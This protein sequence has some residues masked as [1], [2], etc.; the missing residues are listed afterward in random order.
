MQQV[1]L[2]LSIGLYHTTQ[3][4]LTCCH[5]LATTIQALTVK[6]YSHHSCCVCCRG[7]FCV[8]ATH[9]LIIIPDCTHHAGPV[10]T[11]GRV[12]RVRAIG[13]RGSH[14]NHPVLQTQREC[15]CAWVHAG[16]LPGPL[17]EEIRPAIPVPAHIH[18]AQHHT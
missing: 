17:A 12:R 1:E 14:R 10:Q 5:R 8:D 2:Y 4:Y 11:T 13:H 7:H 3:E 15:G 9:T 18:P 16:Y 6:E